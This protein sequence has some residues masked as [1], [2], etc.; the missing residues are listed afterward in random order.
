VT[1]RPQ[2]AAAARRGTA[3]DWAARR[4]QWQ[5][6]RRYRLNEA[7]FRLTILLEFQLTRSGERPADVV[8]NFP[9]I[10]RRIA[11]LIGEELDQWFLL[12]CLR[13]N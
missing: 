11:A 8:G 4:R 13:M 12:H 3:F 2:F 1:E 6:W 10:D 9:R 5:Q 7:R